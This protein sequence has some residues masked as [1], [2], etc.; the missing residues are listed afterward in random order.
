MRQDSNMSLL[1]PL[2]AILIAKREPLFISVIVDAGVAN[3]LFG[4]WM[5]NREPSVENA[6]MEESR[7]LAGRIVAFPGGR[8]F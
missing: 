2:I 4:E 7:G 6:L 8:Y 1:D 3:G 5:W